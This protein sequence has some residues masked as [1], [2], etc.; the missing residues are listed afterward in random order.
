MLSQKNVIYIGVTAGVLLGIMGL[1]AWAQTQ[2]ERN[3]TPDSDDEG[4]GG[5]SKE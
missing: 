4:E 3:V 1:V 5:E 2:D